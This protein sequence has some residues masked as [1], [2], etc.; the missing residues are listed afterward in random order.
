VGL[1]TD[2]WVH[3]ITVCLTVSIDIHV[4]PFDPLYQTKNWDGSIVSDQ[5]EN[6]PI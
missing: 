1:T 5:T 2:K 3:L 6:D 4:I